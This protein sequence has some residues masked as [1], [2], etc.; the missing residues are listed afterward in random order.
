MSINPKSTKPPE[1]INC[2]HCCTLIERNSHSEQYE[3]DYCGVLWRWFS[4]ISKQVTT[5]AQ[6]AEGE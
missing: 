4:P 6:S 1:Y 3:C 5:A 2:P